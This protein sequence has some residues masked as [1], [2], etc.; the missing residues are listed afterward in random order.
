MK[1]I[2]SL[3][4]SLASGFAQSQD[5]A[6]YLKLS[7]SQQSL[8]FAS[9]L[10]YGDAVNSTAGQVSSLS[11]MLLIE[12]NKSSP[13]EAVIGQ[14]HAT[15]ENLCRGNYKSANDTYKANLEVLD[16]GQ[17]GLLQQLVSAGQQA[18]IVEQARALHLLPVGENPNTTQVPYYG[19]GRSSDSLGD[20]LIAY[21]LLTTDQ[22]SQLRVLSS[23]L[24]RDYQSNSNPAI[25]DFLAIFS[26][27]GQTT[28]DLESVGAHY[29]DIEYR[30]RQLN[31]LL[32]RAFEKNRG[33]LTDAQRDRLD[34]LLPGSERE[35]LVEDALEALLMPV[36]AIRPASELT[37]MVTRD[38]IYSKAMSNY[39]FTT[40]AGA[41]SNGLSR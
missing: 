11:E 20:D 14:Q 1:I 24:A 17:R 6:N 41:I 31:T 7:P 40:Q 29:A 27:L 35:P 22:L 12:S 25:G 19:V 21:L 39:L 28:P 18:P 30:R 2:F 23:A 8:I 13:N 5:L 15:I 16:S 10:V 9:T 33:V 38:C 34:S 4:F 3:I 36:D 26:E 32:S 37:A